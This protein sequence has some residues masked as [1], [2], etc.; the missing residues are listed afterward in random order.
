MLAK[1][2]CREPDRAAPPGRGRRAAAPLSARTSCEAA[3]D[4]ANELYAE[5]SAE[6]ADFKTIY[7]SQQAF[8][9]EANLWNQVAEYT[10][11]TFM[12]RNRPRG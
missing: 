6:N 11:D 3:F 8:R 4:A 10:F 9:N 7:E 1:Y 2:D 12:I 5:I